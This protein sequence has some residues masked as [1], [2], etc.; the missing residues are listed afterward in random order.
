MQ[1]M[2]ILTNRVKKNKQVD[3]NMYLPLECFPIQ[4]KIQCWLVYWPRWKEVLVLNY[5]VPILKF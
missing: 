4:P 5:L 2:C 3:G 1:F